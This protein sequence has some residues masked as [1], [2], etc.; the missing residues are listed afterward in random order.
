MSQKFEII[1]MKES[2]NEIGWEE[3]EYALVVF[4]DFKSIEEFVRM[5]WI[6][7]YE[8]STDLDL[9]VIGTFYVGT[10]LLDYVDG[11]YA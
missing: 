9:D 10:G 4:K 7:N 11:N 1:L 6:L 5:N 8:P 2:Q 3:L